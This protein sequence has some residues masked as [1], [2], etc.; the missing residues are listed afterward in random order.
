M[1]AGSTTADSERRASRTILF[2]GDS[3]TRGYGVGREHRFAAVLEAAL[4]GQGN[5]AWQWPVVHAPSDFRSFARRLDYALET[6]PP[7]I[8]V[9]QCPSGP[10]AYFVRYPEWIKRVA[11]LH[12]RGFEWL[13]ERYIGADIRAG[14]EG[15]TRREAL[16]EGRYLNRL[17]GLRPSTWLGVRQARRLLVARYGTEVK[18]TRERYLELAGDARD[19]LRARTRAP[20]LFLGFFPHSDELFPGYTARVTEWNEH[21]AQLLD[22]PDDGFFFLDVLRVL[23]RPGAG[24]VLLSDGMHLSVEGHRRAAEVILPTVTQLMRALDSSACNVSSPTPAS[25]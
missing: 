19:Q 8:L 20:I 9:W 2:F 18:A 10:A 17:Y 15:R 4:A 12:N 13:R 6:Y 24:A 25:P 3:N 11:T 23:N 5:A 21:L 1:E 22:H 14:G 7:D 16:Y